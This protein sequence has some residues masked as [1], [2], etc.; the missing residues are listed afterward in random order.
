VQTA[1]LAELNGQIASTRRDLLDCQEKTKNLSS[2][3]EDVKKLNVRLREFKRMPP[4]MDLPGF[5]G[6]LAQITQVTSIKNFDSKQQQKVPAGPLDRLPIGFT[7]EGDFLNVF[8]FLQRAENLPRLTRIPK[9]SIRRRDP[10][11][12]VKVDLTMEIYSLAE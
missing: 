4:Q 11:G 3:A 12:Q 1:R 8:A 2:V 7:F 6:E 9:V 5:I 10:Q